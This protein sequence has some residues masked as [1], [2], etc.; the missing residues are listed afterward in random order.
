MTAATI[1]EV[2]FMG[3]CQDAL[4]FSKAFKK[5]FDLSPRN[6]RLS[7]QELELRDERPQFP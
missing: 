5:R 4:V 3:P 1:E 6:Y 2:Y 7:R